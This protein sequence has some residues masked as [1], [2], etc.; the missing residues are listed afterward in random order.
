[1]S[2]SPPSPPAVATPEEG[3]NEGSKL[4]TFLGILRKFIGVT[5]LASVRFSLPS[6]LLEP[7][8]N[9]EYWTYLD[10]PNAFVA[11]G[12]SDEPLDRMLEVIRFW[13]TK[14]LKYAKGKPCK[15]YNSCLGEFFRCNWETEDN[16]PRI[17]TLELQT[18]GSSSS[19]I[20]GAAAK[21]EN[22]SSSVSLSVPQHGT[23]S[24]EAG[25][26]LRISYLT[27][28]TSHHPPVSAFYVTCP[29]KGITA[30][31]FD[32]ITAKFTGTSV[33]VLPGEHN[34]GIFITLE[35][36]D[37]E[38]YQLTHPAAHLGGLFRGTLSVSVSEMAYITCPDTKIKAILHYV[39]EG[40]LGRTTNKIDGVIFKY[41]PENDDKTR[42]QDV[43]DEDVLARLSGPWKER[44]VFSLGPRPMKNVPPEEQHVIID[45]LPLNVA[46]KVL[47]PKESMLPNESLRLWGGVTDAIL[48]KQFSKA[49]ELKVALEEAQREKARKREQNNETWKPVFFEHS[50]GNGGKPDLNDK[51]KQVLERAQKGDWNLEGIL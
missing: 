21:S 13:L 17:N 25:Q 45:I 7:T 41:D 35:K 4:R 32:Q 23:A 44:V 37:N 47:P 34:S 8:P 2:S 36:R 16:A 33:K 31:G 11:I 22:S 30:R 29:E 3:H 19:S 14:D 18:P 9:L 20:K 39:E 43:P 5:D 15:P 1:M 40:W 27:E 12:T 28:Q 49:T 48:S 50:V 26:L 24:N 6:Q 10:A 38:T 46:P 51:G 42:V